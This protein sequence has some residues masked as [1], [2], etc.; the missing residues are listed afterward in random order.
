VTDASPGPV[1]DLPQAPPSPSA[2]RAADRSRRLRGVEAWHRDIISALSAPAVVGQFWVELDAAQRLVRGSAPGEGKLTLTH[3][4]AKAAALSALSSPALHR[5]YGPFGALDPAHADVGVSVE[6]QEVLA[7]VVVLREADRKPLVEIARELRALAAE[8]RERD[9]RDAVLFDRYLKLFPFPQLRRL[10]IRAVLSSAKARRLAA[11]TLQF[12]NIGHFGIDA[13][14]VPVVVELL[15]VGG[16]V[17]R[18]P[19]ADEEDRVRVALGAEFTLHGSHR[20][21]NGQTAG[22]FI[23]TFRSLMAQPER[24]L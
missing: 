2:P 22:Q 20:K 10:L 9:A 18:R 12:S 15:L 21:V 7:P 13:A 4:F 3:L 8:A 1:S 5:M 6:G 23:R 24:L 14:Q 17:Q 11:G 19:V 16:V